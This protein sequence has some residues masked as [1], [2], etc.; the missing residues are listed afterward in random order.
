MNLKS[1]KTLFFSI[2]VAIS[3]I[4]CNNDEDYRPNENFDTGAI[5]KDIDFMDEIEIDDSFFDQDLPS[6]FQLVSKDNLLPP[7]I[8]AQ[9]NSNK[10]VAYSIGYIMDF[11][12][13]VESGNTNYE[14]VSSP[15]YIF[16][17]YKSE[18]NDDCAIGSQ[19]AQPNGKG[20]G[21]LLVT[22]GTCFW[23]TLSPPDP[24]TQG[25]TCSTLTGAY[26]QEAQTNKPLAYYALNETAIN[27][28]EK[29]KSFIHAGY[30]IHF[31]IEIGD[32]FSKLGSDVWEIKDRDGTLGSHA[33]V[34][35]GW[36]DSKNAYKIANSWGREWGE[37]G[38][39][40]IDYEAMKTA[41]SKYKNA[42][43]VVP[44]A[45][46]NQN[47]THLGGNCEFKQWG[48]IKIDNQLS[49]LIDVDMINTAN[50][51]FIFPES[52][53]VNPSENSLIAGIPVGNIEII[54]KNAA[55]IIIHQQ[56]Y[57]LTACETETI[58]IQ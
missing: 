12:N 5:L 57:N 20:L 25:Y 29:M 7:P 56:T 21:Q 6:K 15:E 28:T 19:L 47:L 50:N 22:N 34:I 17:L 36:D 3:F 16:S 35:V 31:A 33:M 43:I 49:E 55:G 8:F 26:H 23:N 45:I 32:E 38:Y 44:S 42:F 9:G 37:N 18:N 13:G 48:S 14:S 24:Q 52:D 1:F 30:P 46:Q 11:Y 41:L 53:K 27:D 39:G 54:I 40:W 4:A 58:T 2:I 10:C 51:N